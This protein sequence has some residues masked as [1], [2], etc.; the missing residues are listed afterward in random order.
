MIW[1]CSTRSSGRASCILTSPKCA[2]GE[3][4]MAGR[5]GYVVRVNLGPARVGVPLPCLDRTKRCSGRGEPVPKVSELMKS[6]VADAGRGD[7]GA[8][9]LA[10]LRGVEDVAAERIDEEAVSLAAPAR[11]LEVPF[12]LAGGRPLIGTLRPR[13][14]FRESNAPRVWLSATRTRPAT[15]SMSH[16]RRPMSSP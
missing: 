14:D 3:A 10:E 2:L 12:E 1:C 16:Q 15:Q 5:V 4:G 11:S 7:R 9:P 8:E 6:Q 13:C